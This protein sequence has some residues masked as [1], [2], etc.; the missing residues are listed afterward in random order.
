MHRLKLSISDLNLMTEKLSLET[1]E[2]EETEVT[3][4]L[5]AVTVESHC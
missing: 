3:E 5:R 2:V 4:E 1:T